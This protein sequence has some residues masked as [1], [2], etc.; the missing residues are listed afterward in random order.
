[1]NTK[2]KF[3]FQDCTVQSITRYFNLVSS[4]FLQG[5]PKAI[6]MLG[7]RQ[8]IVPRHV[9]GWKA[10]AFRVFLNLWAA[11]PIWVAK[12]CVIVVLEYNCMGFQ[13]V[14]Y[15]ALWVTNYQRLRTAGVEQTW[16]K[17]G[18][19]AACIPPKIFCGPHSK[20]I[21]ALLNFWT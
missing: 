16:P 6:R 20:F 17:W 2:F 5:S 14:F 12:T 19:W 21:K 3:T 7:F 4:N 9:K 11:I 15:S 1:M 18:P 10:L 8:K 13:T